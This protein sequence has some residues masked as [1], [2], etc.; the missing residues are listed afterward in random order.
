MRRTLAA[1]ALAAPLVALSA[2]TAAANNGPNTFGL[3]CGGWALHMFPY[4]H[5]HGPL[6]N[7]GPYYG[8]APFQPYGPWDAYLRYTGDGYGGAGGGGGA[9]GWYN[10]WQPGAH[11]HGHAWAHPNWFQ[12]GN[13]G[14]ASCGGGHVFHHG[15]KG[16]C[17]TCG[18]AAAAIV[19][20][21]PALAR[22]NG[23]GD[24]AA[25]AA[26][27]A[28]SPSLVVPVSGTTAP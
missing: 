5:Q 20:S 28:E 25:S 1:A 7:Y 3:R 26:F 27:Y 2:G 17:S 14:C 6:F 10:G 11:L 24:P 16:G 4:L 12:H 9:Y 13:H 23:H 22:F 18:A 21:G 19:T 8:Y 15:H